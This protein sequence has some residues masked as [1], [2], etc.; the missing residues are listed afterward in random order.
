MLR[1]VTCVRTLTLALLGLTAVASRPAAADYMATIAAHVHMR[2][3]PAIEYPSVVLLTAGAPVQVYGCEQ[4]YGWCDVQAGPD[5]G[6]VAGE[7]LQMPAPSGPVF[8]AGGGVG[9]GIPIISFN[10]NTYWGSY[11]RSRPWFARQP[12]YSRYWQRYP[13]GVPPPPRPP[14]H[15]RP[16]PRPRP[17]PP[18]PGPGRPRPPGAGPGPKPPPPAGGRPPGNR[19]PGGGAPGER[20]S[21]D[22]P[23]LGNRPPG[24]GAPGD[25]PSGNR[26]SPGN[27]PSGGGAPGDRPRQGGDRPANTPPG[28]PGQ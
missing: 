12:Y 15:V 2:A 24:A 8:I 28:G 13:H 17:P 20:P 16:P 22:R 10:F 9:L 6:W 25:R 21:G 19:P 7:Y 27:R 1:S 11:Y 3:G 23:N 18:G 4:D 14:M 26:P 5:R